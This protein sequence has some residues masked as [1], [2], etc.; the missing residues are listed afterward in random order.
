MF[1]SM[2]SERTSHVRVERLR[3]LALIARQEATRAAPSMSPSGN[4]DQ[5]CRDQDQSPA[6]VGVLAR[7][8]FISS[9]DHY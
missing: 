2:F 9:L 3:G 7:H 6:L 4:S 8:I 1:H 5:R